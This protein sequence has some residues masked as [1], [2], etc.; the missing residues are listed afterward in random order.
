ME[1]TEN[2]QKA[3]D[4]LPFPKLSAEWYRRQRTKSNKIHQ[5]NKAV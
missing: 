1:V 5:E 4:P 2:E 3:A